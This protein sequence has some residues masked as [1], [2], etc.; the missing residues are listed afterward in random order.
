M[1]KARTKLGYIY[2]DFPNYI[3]MEF[4]KIFDRHP[5]IPYYTLE[6]LPIWSIPIFIHPEKY[7]DGTR[8]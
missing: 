8:W 4:M 6:V 3:P 5:K 1:L 2:K 7:V